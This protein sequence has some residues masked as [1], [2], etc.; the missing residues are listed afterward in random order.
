MERGALELA[1]TGKALDVL[2]RSERMRRLL[3]S[4]RIFARCTPEQK[5]RRRRPCISW[6]MHPSWWLH[7]E[8]KTAQGYQYPRRVTPKEG[9]TR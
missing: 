1:V 5:A 8:D 6:N 9:R 3:F 7:R 2:L 4:T